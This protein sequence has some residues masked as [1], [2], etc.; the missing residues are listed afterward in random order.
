MD[1]DL[2]SRLR[3]AWQ[4]CEERSGRLIYRPQGYLHYGVA[5]SDSFM[6]SWGPSKPGSLEDLG[7]LTLEPLSSDLVDARH[8]SYQCKER[9]FLNLIASIPAFHARWRYGMQG[10]NCEHWARLVTTGDPVSYQIAETGF[11][12]LD[13]TGSLRRHRSAQ[14]HLSHYVN[15]VHD[16][17]CTEALAAK[18]LPPK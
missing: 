2:L 9:I 10:W 17:W 13:V 15:E 11:G 3:L 1:D 5:V 12:L 7:I 14:D 8:V 6:I 4:P 18:D 16:L